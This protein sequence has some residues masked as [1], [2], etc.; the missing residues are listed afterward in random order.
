VSI[1]RRDTNSLLNRLAGGNVFPGEHHAAQ[2]RVWKTGERLNLEMRSEDGATIVRVLARLEKSLPAQSVFRSLKEASDFF[3]NGSLGW[4][5]RPKASEFDGLELRCD[6]WRMH[7]LAVERV[8]SSFFED[9]KLFPPGSAT[10]DSA[11]L[12]RDLDH[13]W[14]ARG[15]LAYSME[16][17]A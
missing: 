10:F 17:V 15:R 6:E 7:P 8:E 3:R 5:A 16:Q 12:M 2:F 4:S 1:P 11:F 9:R 13:S 14:H